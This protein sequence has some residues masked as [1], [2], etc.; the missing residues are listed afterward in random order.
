MPNDS[1]S[2]Q[3]L[4]TESFHRLIEEVDNCV[5]SSEKENLPTRHAV[6]SDIDEQKLPLSSLCEMSKSANT[7]FQV[8]PLSLDTEDGTSLSA[9]HPSAPSPP[10]SMPQLEEL[11]QAQDSEECRTL[12]HN[13]SNSQC[14]DNRPKLSEGYGE[15]DLT[16]LIV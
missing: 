3:E 11:Q 2:V 13:F 7:D 1:V 5:F 6:E 4:S 10:Y 12:E 14:Q 16:R 15:L 8:C 9:E